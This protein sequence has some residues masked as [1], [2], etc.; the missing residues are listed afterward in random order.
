[1]KKLGLIFAVAF[2]VCIIASGVSF[3]ETKHPWADMKP[4]TSAKWITKMGAISTEMTMTVKSNDG[5][6]LVYE[7]ATKMVMNGKALSD[8]KTD[9]KMK[10]E[11]K[12]GATNAMP[13]GWKKTGTETIK[14]AA[15]EFE[16]E[17][18]EGPNSA[19]IW[20]S[21]KVPFSMIVKMK[22]ASM[23][24]ELASCDTK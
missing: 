20:K 23:T 9:V 19:K 5:K 7:M 12:E 24:Q 14:V 1:M 10:L 16:C 13:K 3:A 6:V 8:N 4:G 21:E 17:V 22:T 18:W 11:V 2:V 15:G